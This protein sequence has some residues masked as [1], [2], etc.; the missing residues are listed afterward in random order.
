MK[1][2]YPEAECIVCSTSRRP[3]GLQLFPLKSIQWNHRATAD[4]S[5]S[6]GSRSPISSLV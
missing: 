5:K 2:G 6:Q 3:V 4:F 1:S